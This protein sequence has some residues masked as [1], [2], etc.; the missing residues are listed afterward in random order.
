MVFVYLFE[1]IDER[2]IFVRPYDSS[3][4]DY[5]LRVFLEL[6]VRRGKKYPYSCCFKEFGFQD[7]FETA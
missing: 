1:I 2:H 5:V 7:L 4:A 3:S 6:L